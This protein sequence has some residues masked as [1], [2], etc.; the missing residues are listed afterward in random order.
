MSLSSP[1]GL[2]HMPVLACASARRTGLPVDN[3]VTWFKP[4]DHR[5]HHDDLRS[6]PPSLRRK[7]AGVFQTIAAE[8]AAINNTMVDPVP[9]TDRNKI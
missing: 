4:Q 7:L 2:T 8:I 1:S 3:L 6:F 5:N 9:P